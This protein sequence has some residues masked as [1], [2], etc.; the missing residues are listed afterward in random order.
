VSPRF[1]IIGAGPAGLGAAYRLHDLGVDDYVVLEASDHVGGLAS[2]YRDDQNFTWDVGGHVQFSH[3]PYFDA[4]MDRALGVDGWNHL[5]RECWVWVRQGFVPYPF[6]NN[7]RHL[8]AADLSRCLIG[9]MLNRL[10]PSRTRPENFREWIHQSFGSGIASVF[11]EPYN[12][13]VWAYPPEMLSHEWVGDRVA[14]VDLNRILMNIMRRRDD[15]SWGPNNRF[16]SPKAGG[17]GAIWERVAD[18]CGRERIRLNCGVTSVS[19]KDRTIRT[20]EGESVSYE[21]VL[22]TMPVD[23][24]CGMIEDVDP[25]LRALSGGLRYSSSNIIG[26]GV[27]GMPPEHLRTKCWMYFPESD[28]PFYRVTVFSNFSAENVARPGH[29]WS[30]MAEVSESSVKPVDAEQLRGS[31]LD[32]LRRTRLLPENAEIVSV[33]TYRA[34][35]GYP[36]PSLGRTRILE[37]LHSSLDALDIYSRGRFGGWK[38]EVSNQDHTFMQGVE[39]ANRMATGE[40]ELTLFHPHKV[41]GR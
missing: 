27:A 31:V 34:P 19:A 35:Y 39:W 7:L 36:T 9:L 30:M 18:L 40:P 28:C 32:G 26:V 1:V 13:K 23:R 29:Q 38:Y 41:N 22:S 20:S 2:S 25:A 24:L 15:V 37:Q 3:Y 4:V 5:N 12:F 6:Q 16:R 14:S 21:S 8:P 17:T 10:R 33:W 11:M